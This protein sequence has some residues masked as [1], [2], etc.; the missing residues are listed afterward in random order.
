MK[1]EIENADI[2]DFVGFDPVKRVVR[3]LMAEPPIVDSAKMARCAVG[4][5]ISVAGTVITA[6]AALIQTK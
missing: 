6:E 5:A 3:D 2:A 4:T 1:L